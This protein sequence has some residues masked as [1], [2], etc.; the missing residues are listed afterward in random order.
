MSQLAHYSPLNDLWNLHDDFASLF[1]KG[2][3][4]NTQFSPR[5]E[6]SENEEAYTIEAEL[7]GLEKDDVKIALRDG[8]LSFSGKKEF[9]KEENKKKE[10]YFKSEFYY[11]TFE[12]SFHLPD[13]IDAEKV[14]A[15]MDKGVLKILLP[16]LEEKKPK[17]IQIDI[18]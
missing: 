17:D 7:P 16:K 18:A 12:R 13:S 6:I 2:A 10:H 8:V 3:L 11:G 5:V 9:R 4:K 1:S 15:R 14:Q